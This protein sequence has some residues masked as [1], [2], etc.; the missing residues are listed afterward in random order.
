M[1]FEIDKNIGMFSKGLNKCDSN[2]LA[3]LSPCKLKIHPHLFSGLDLEL[4]VSSV[5]KITK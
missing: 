1:H 4:C 3:F 2:S 5:I